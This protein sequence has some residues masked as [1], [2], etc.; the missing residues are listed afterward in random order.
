ML[1]ALRESDRV[2]GV[3]ARIGSLDVGWAKATETRRA[4]VRLKDSG[5]RVDCQ[6]FGRGDIVYY[7]ASAC[8]SVIITPPQML[9]MNGLAAEVLFFGEA[10]DRLGVRVD[11]VRRGAYKNS[12][13]QFARSGMSVAHR[14]ALGA[15]LDT[16]FEALVDGIAEGRGIEKD[17]VLALIDRG[18]FTS[19]E[20]VALNLVDE[21]LYPDEVE[22]H[23]REHY[24]GAARFARADTLLPATRP[25]WA[26]RSGIA[27][28]HVDAAITGGESRDLPLG[29]GQTVGARTLIGAIESARLRSDVRAVVLR[30]DSPG[31]DAVASDLVA[32]AIRKLAE[33]KPVIASF[34]DIAASGGY[35]VAADASTIYAEPTT[36]TGSIGV[37]SVA[38]AFEDLLARLGVHT[39]VVERGANA[40]AGSA[41]TNPSPEALAMIRK[42]V[43]DAYEMFLDVV[44]RGRKLDKEKIRELAEGRIWSGRDAKARGLVDELGGLTDAVR[45]AKLAA[46]FDEDDPIDLLTLPDTRAPLPEPVRT[47]VGVFTPE[48]PTV[49][50]ELLPP[51][52]RQAVGTWLAPFGDGRAH[53]LTLA[54]WRI[55]IR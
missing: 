8:T 6:L 31:G 21:R 13:D 22:D 14:E 41:Y 51:A 11:V 46:G 44:A 16:V 7:L 39:S 28:I 17:E 30:V 45:A 24:G 35:Y 42:S 50:R 15:Y 19:S 29:L 36:L 20:A 34:G 47:I 33:E 52:L 23:I 1:D 32:R 9:E 12:P 4:L 26:G 37:F 54:P 40:N 48:D 53:A 38:F 55:R 3:F 5:R 43:D 10:L 27:I 2:K 25:R 18:T 49:I